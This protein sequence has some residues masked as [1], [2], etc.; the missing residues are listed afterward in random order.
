MQDLNFNTILKPISSDSP[1]GVDLRE[2]SVLNALYYQIKD[3]RQKARQAE[4]K[5][6]MQE[7]DDT[8]LASWKELIVIAIDVL[9]N[10]SKDLEIFAWLIEA[11]LRVYQFAG[12]AQG[13]AVAIELIDVFWETLF[14]IMEDNDLSAKLA[15]FIGLNGE[16]SPGSL[17]QPIKSVS[18][19]AVKSGRNFAL[20]HY[21][22][23]LELEKISDTQK[24][25]QRIKELGYHLH[26]IQQA[27]KDSP[28]KFY[29]SLLSALTLCQENHKKLDETFFR[30]CGVNAPPTSYIRNALVDVQDHIHFLLQDLP[31]S[32]PSVIS[33]NTTVKESVSITNLTEIRFNNRAEALNLLNSISAYFSKLEPHSPVP[34]LLNRAVRWANMPL[35]ELWRELIVEEETRKN[36]GKLTGV[37][38]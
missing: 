25:N 32:S 38:F 18:I 17:I 9:S 28:P 6:R 21:L 23:A 26:E 34:F 2:D 5:H 12:L 16:D 3:L 22:H 11:L 27:V 29:Q 10:K 33:E 14:P 7:S 19:T 4:T 31:V 30:H 37:E 13:F 24:K 1:A 35:P 8:G 20:C 36:V 15:A